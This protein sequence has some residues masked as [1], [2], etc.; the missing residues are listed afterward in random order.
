[1]YL[2]YKS[3]KDTP[4]KDPRKFASVSKIQGLNYL[5]QSPNF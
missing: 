3:T 4:K 5:E 2:P 1:M